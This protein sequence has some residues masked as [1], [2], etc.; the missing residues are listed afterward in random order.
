VNEILYNYVLSS[1]Q[2]SGL[3]PKATLSLPLETKMTSIG[4]SSMLKVYSDHA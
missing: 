3:G 1:P 4:Y 2:L